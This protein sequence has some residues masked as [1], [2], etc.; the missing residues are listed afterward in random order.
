[1]PLTCPFLQRLYLLLTSLTTCTVSVN[2][3]TDWETVGYFRK[4]ILHESYIYS[5]RLYM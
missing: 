4:D 3:L 2:V 5:S 1:M